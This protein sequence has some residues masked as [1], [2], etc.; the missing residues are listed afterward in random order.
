[1]NNKLLISI[2]SVCFIL[3]LLLAMTIV[4]SLD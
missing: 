2:V 4:V 3:L 1:M